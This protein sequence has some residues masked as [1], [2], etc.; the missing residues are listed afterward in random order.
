[1]QKWYTHPSLCND[2]IIKIKDYYKIEI[3]DSGF[4]QISLVSDYNSSELDE[5][6]ISQN[7][8]G[9]NHFIRGRLSKN[10]K[11]LITKYYIR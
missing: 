8:I 5:L 7:S 6:L 9:W 4:K 11:L 3:H 1:M 10:F 2:I